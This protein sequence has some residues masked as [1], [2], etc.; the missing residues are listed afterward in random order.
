[1]ILAV[2]RPRVGSGLNGGSRPAASATAAQ[3]QGAQEQSQYAAHP[4]GSWPPQPQPS[5]SG[6][7]VADDIGHA[8]TRQAVETSRP[9]HHPPSRDRALGRQP[10]APMGP[11][12][13]HGAEEYASSEPEGVYGRSRQ[14]PRQPDPFGPPPAPR[15]D[16]PSHS[17]QADG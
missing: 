6:R 5:D 13:S 12:H 2:A 7:S 3:S 14:A 16:W 11:T 15:L 4:A 10:L 1:E 17:P 9:P 8:S